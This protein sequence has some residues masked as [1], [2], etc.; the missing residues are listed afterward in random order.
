MGII[1]KNVIA[2]RCRYDSGTLALGFAGNQRGGNPVVIIIEMTYRFV[3]HNE[4]E[5]LADTA[6][7]GHALLLAY[8]HAAHGV[9][10][11]R[12]YA[13]L[14]EPLL[15]LPIGGMP[16]QAILYLYILPRRQFGKERE[17]LREIGQGSATK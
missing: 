8:R 13:E 1:K 7:N 6:D 3:E 12:G 14:L 15:Y 9:I 4:I 17:L 5:W 2:Y 11:P 16:G 10:S